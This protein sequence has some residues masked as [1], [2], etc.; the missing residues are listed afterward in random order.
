MHVGAQL[1]ISLP[2]DP[3]RHVCYED[4]MYPYV[5]IA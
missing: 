2:W 3:S 1:K 4:L 5:C